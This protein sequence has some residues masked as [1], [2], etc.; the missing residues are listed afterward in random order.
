[1]VDEEE[2]YSDILFATAKE[3]LRRQFALNFTHDVLCPGCGTMYPAERVWSL[4]TSP[5]ENDCPVPVCTY[6]HCPSAEVDPKPCAGRLFTTTLLTEAQ[7]KSLKKRIEL[8]AKI[9]TTGEG[10]AER[11][12]HAQPMR[13]GCTLDYEQFLRA[14]AS[15]LT[16]EEFD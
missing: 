7:R 4:P 15:G 9:V 16:A 12:F 2:D 1:P 14:W 6:L 11:H 3:R 5:D 10:D 8:P 13:V